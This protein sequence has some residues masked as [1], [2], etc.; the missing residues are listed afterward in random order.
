MN[1]HNDKIRKLIADKQNKDSNLS[2]Y[3]NHIKVIDKYIIFYDNN[4][5][6]KDFIF[7][8]FINGFDWA[9][10]ENM[11]NEL[12]RTPKD[13]QTKNLLKNDRCKFTARWIGKN[14]DIINELYKIINTDDGNIL[15]KSNK[16]YTIDYSIYEKL[17]NYV[18]NNKNEIMGSFKSIRYTKV[19]YDSLLKSILKD[20]TGV[21]MKYSK[22]YDGKTELQDKEWTIK[23]MI[24]DNV[25]LIVIFKNSKPDYNKFMFDDDDIIKQIKKWTK[26]WN[27]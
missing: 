2:N 22:Y 6:K 17:I 5:V 7:E 8:F 23:N 1:E 11:Q 27:H 19:S 12:F 20:W 13:T 15:N 10:F 4:I 3:Y 18:K 21:N 16:Y 25:G 14:M 9:K 26:K 24:Y